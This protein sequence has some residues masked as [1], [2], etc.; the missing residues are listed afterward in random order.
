MVKI[1]AERLVEHL[2]RAG[3]VPIDSSRRGERL[4]GSAPFGTLQHQHLPGRT[5]A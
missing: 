4:L 2:E 5:A 1:T 3:F